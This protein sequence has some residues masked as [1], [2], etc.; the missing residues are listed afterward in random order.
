MIKI[1]YVKITGRSEYGTKDAASGQTLMV[2]Q[3]SCS[4][5]FIYKFLFDVL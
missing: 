5:S 1:S 2:M 4:N 3:A